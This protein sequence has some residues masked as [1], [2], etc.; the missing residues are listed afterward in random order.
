MPGNAI[1]LDANLLLLFIVGAASPSYIARHKRL[2]GYHV[3]D[4]DL[5]VRLLSSA[6]SVSVTPNAVTEASNLARYIAEPARTEIAKKLRGF[7]DEIREVYIMSTRAA[8][9]DGYIRLGITDAG[10][11]DNEF[12]DHLLLTADLDLYLEAARQGRRTE[13]FNHYIQ[14]GL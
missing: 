12:A 10:M 3:R 11:L 4:Y 13:N 14:A 1:L 9:A 6:A 8:A 2:R 7:L 5:L